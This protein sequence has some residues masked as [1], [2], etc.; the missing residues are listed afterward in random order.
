MPSTPIH[1]LAVDDEPDLCHL[2]K[3]FLEIPGEMEVDTVFTVREARDVLSKI[4]YDAVVSDYQMPCEDGIQ[5]LKSL[6]ASGDRTPFILFTGR[7]REEVVI[8]AL[9]SGADSYLQKGGEP[10]SQYAELGHRI[11]L[12]AQRRRVEEALLDSESEFRTLFEN[13]PDP[14]VLVSFDGKILNTNQAG[15]R[16]VLMRK[17]EIIE[18]SIFDL[19]VFSEN[20]V[21]LFRRTMSAMAKGEPV[22]PVV[23][24]VLR[25]DGTKRWVEILAST[26][27]KAGCDAFQIIGRDITDRVDAEEALRK[28]E[29]KFRAIF[30]AAAVG[31]TLVGAEG[32]P[33]GFND[34]FANYLGYSREE[35]SRMSFAEATYPGDLEKN[36]AFIKEF[37]AG[38]IDHYDMEKRFVRKDGEIV[39]A[40]LFVNLVE[41]HEGEPP[42]ILAIIDD[43]T[44]RKR[45]EEE[46]LRS[47]AEHRR[48]IDNSHDIIYTMTKDGI[49]T[50]VSPS[51]TTLLGHP[52]DQVVGRPFHSFVHADDLAGCLAYL[53]GAI[54]TGQRQTGIEYRV[55]H[56][57][58]SWRWHTSNG[59]PLIDETGTAVG[60][61][62]IASDITVQKQAKAALYE[63]N[64][65]LNLLSS[66]TRHDIKN[67]LMVLEGNLKLLDMNRFDGS[68]DRLLQNAEAAAKRISAMIQFTKEYENIGV[69]APIWQNVMTLVRSGA[70]DI[71]LGED[72][73]V[74]DV[75]ADTMVFADPLIVKVFHNLLNNAVRHGGRVTAVHFYLE[76]RNGVSAIV[77]EDDGVGIPAD[78][79]AKLFTKGIGKDHGLGLFLSR[80]IL[81]ITDITIT[82]EGDPGKGA[83]FVLTPPQ[84]GIRTN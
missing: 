43:L 16:M 1:I 35:L 57:D 12:L 41:A 63:A 45:S 26:V 75:P 48:L 8:E 71:L 42:L 59:V 83:K 61:E 66:I 22:S 72:M 15:A 54:E 62:G 5:F 18:R 58:G 49:F 60:V 2:T 55:R 28:S 52:I 53:K 44:E 34:K 30:N 79:K 68:S 76:E 81:A 3:I 9:N 4:R 84:D 36:L 47:E 10:E 38:K 80:E 32:K 37:N 67:Q 6:R 40:H 46:L 17:E 29:G 11:R 39:W 70:K 14:V 65:K 21:A 64:R 27:I 13:N 73:V 77:C 20:D 50:F 24:Q 7:G 33:Y 56:A 78:M 74:N 69:Q 51:W 25:K 31:I 19:G 23:S 82:E